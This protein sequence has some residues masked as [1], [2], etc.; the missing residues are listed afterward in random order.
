[1]WSPRVLSFVSGF[2]SL[3]LEILWV[4]Y[5]GFA[6]RG[7]PQAFSFVLGMYL[8]GIAIGAG[9]G[10]RACQRRDDLWN[11]AGTVLVVAG[12]L[13]FALA[14]L[15]TAG[16]AAGKL[17]GIVLLSA[18]VVITA[19]LQSMVFPIAHHLGSSSAA[20]RVG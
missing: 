1:M 8:V 3:S 4:R 13:D 10:R 18:A 6:Y 11:V 17:P 9:L 2:I 20:A 16:F 5:A 14:W 19:L 15:A 7:A 12:G